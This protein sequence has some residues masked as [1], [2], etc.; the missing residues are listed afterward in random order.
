MERLNC[1]KK[2]YMFDHAEI[3]LEYFLI[4]KNLYLDH[5][6]R[7]RC[8]KFATDSVIKIE[9]VHSTHVYIYSRSIVHFNIFNFI[10]LAICSFPFSLSPFF[11]TKTDRKS[12]PLGKFR[13]CALSRRPPLTVYFLLDVLLHWFSGELSPL[14]PSPMFV[15]T[16]FS[17][18]VT[19]ATHNYRSKIFSRFMQNARIGRIKNRDET[20]TRRGCWRR[21]RSVHLKR[22]RLA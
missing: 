13:L 22:E 2:I 6:S 15:Q 11:L 17:R 9:S 16:R 8:S 18:P 19:I 3:D 4:K 5:S 7:K 21:V 14:F 12:N 10:S 1:G 20:C